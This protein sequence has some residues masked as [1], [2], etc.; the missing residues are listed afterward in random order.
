MK[1]TFL[2]LIYLILAL[3]AISANDS[4]RINWPEAYDPSVSKF[5]VHNEIEIKASPEKVWPILLDALHWS[6]WYSGASELRFE[7]SRDSVL[8]DGAAFYWKTMGLHFRSE[9]KEFELNRL[10]AWESKKSSIQGYHVWLIIPTAEGCKVI[11]DES[12]NGWIT[13][14]EKIFQGNKLHR[15]HD[16]WL[17][18]L[19]MKAES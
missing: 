15:Q 19:K 14:F 5:Y 18:G 16:E 2:G 4:D 1:K 10:L 6:D 11:T 7:N 13:F 17:A 8:H 9:I 3:G 12:Q